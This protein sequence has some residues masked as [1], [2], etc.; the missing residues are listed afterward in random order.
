MLGQCCYVLTLNI[1]KG[2]WIGFIGLPNKN[3]AHLTCYG[4]DGA[5]HL[6]TSS[7]HV[8]ALLIL[9]CLYHRQDVALVLGLHLVLWASFK[10][11]PLKG[12]EGID[13]R[14]RN[15]SFKG[16]ILR[17]GA[18]FVLYWFHDLDSC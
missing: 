6:L 8:L 2:C 18:L 15:L 10:W 12:P 11:L 14:V 17:L 13:A 7:E 1:N 16:N 9:H 4:E 5:A 3:V